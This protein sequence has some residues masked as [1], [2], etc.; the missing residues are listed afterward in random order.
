MGGRS[1]KFF[2]LIIEKIKDGMKEF[3]EK[4]YKRNGKENVFIPHFTPKNSVGE[5]T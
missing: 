2:M 3:K 5:F 4:I 1:I